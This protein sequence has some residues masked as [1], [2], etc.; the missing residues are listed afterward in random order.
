MTISAPAPGR[1]APP[2]NPYVGPF[3]FGRDQRLPNREREARELADLVISERVVL[4][5]APSGAG[6]T[7]IIQAAVLP[8]LDGFHAVGPL[9]VDKPVPTDADGRPWKVHN[10][11][12]FSVALYLLGDGDGVAP[13]LGQLT[14]SEILARALP[15]AERGRLPLV[16]FD[17]VEE[18]LT[19]DP[20]DW[21]A[22]EQFFRE[23]GAAIADRGLWVLLAM[24]E[25]YIGGMDRC[26]RFVPGHLRSR[27]RLDFLTHREAI[28]AIRKPAAAQGVTVTDEAA[29]LLVTK[30]SQTKVQA[31][32]HG[33]ESKLAPYVEP[34]Q[35]QVV[36]RRLWKDVR[37]AKGDFH[38]I[39]DED[40]ERHVDV[41]RALT[42]YY[43]DS[44]GEL[45][46]SFG[47]SERLIRD[48][49][50]HQLI[51]AQGFRSQTTIPPVTGDHEREILTRLREMFLVNSDTRGLTTWYEL[52]H[53]RLIPAVRASNRAWRHDHLEP[54]QNAALDWVAN[55]RQR[56]FLLK[57]ELLSTA[58]SVRR[59][60]LA[61]F[62]RD[63]L[64]ESYEDV[65]N[66]FLLQ[67]YRYTLT[68]VSVI[69]VIELVVILVLV[70][71]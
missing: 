7:S 60:D 46:R 16:V 34:F 37:K 3:P 71:G 42:R 32:E 40:V 4:L 18:I 11:Y 57:S 35:L 9:R 19:L 45:A 8:L 66:R 55:N 64:R 63:F 49:F 14:L 31:P 61:D 20:T 56:A 6:K 22:K 38:V 28:A 5:H 21:A 50:E 69:A 43:S 30:L 41:E 67:A 15:P 70:L 51:T 29:Q 68:I 47:A 10:R 53:D 48:W 44:V 2:R 58:P 26:L 39:D 12:V 23:L 13:E 65:G 27:Y 62:E 54:W 1:K 59:K 33:V 17:Q 25:D 24:R 36:C 52:A